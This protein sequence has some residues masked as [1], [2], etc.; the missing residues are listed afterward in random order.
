ML[1]W[2]DGYAAEA[3]FRPVTEEATAAECRELYTELD[4]H[5]TAEPELRFAAR[6]GY[7]QARV[8][9]SEPDNWMAVCRNDP[10]GAQYLGTAM[11]P[12]AKDRIQLFGAEDTV[13]KSNLVVGR[14]PTGT[15][16]IRA[17]LASG[18][19]VTGSHDGDVFVIWTVDDSVQGAQLTATTADGSV[20]AAATAPAEF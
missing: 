17:R 13:M 1:S 14:V 20:I 6:D 10:P 8:Y 9:V 18:R 11:E 7:Y 3:A 19:I 5:L 4:S 16:T 2:L 15:T 12:G